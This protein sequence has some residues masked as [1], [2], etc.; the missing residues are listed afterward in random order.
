MEANAPKVSFVPAVNVTAPDEFVVPT[1]CLRT[2]NCVSLAP[3]FVAVKCVLTGLFGILN[4]ET[5]FSGSISLATLI[6]S[7]PTFEEPS[8]SFNLLFSS[9]AFSSVPSSI[10]LPS[11][12]IS[13]ITK[14][15]VKSVVPSSPK[16]CLA[17]SNLCV[18]I[19][20]CLPSIWAIVKSV[21]PEFST[22]F[23]VSAES[24]AII[25]SP[26]EKVPTT[27]VS[28]KRVCSPSSP[29]TV[30]YDGE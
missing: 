19:E 13:A 12:S 23:P 26:W 7:S 10:I 9:T 1:N 8:S 25:F 27:F 3:E 16:T 29:N 30:V 24:D 6:G 21:F 14:S 5:F 17:S 18:T 15:A 2:V 20:L 11:S 22:I 4:I 28:A